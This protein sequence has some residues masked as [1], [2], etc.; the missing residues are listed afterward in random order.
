MQL[1]YRTVSMLATDRYVITGARDGEEAYRLANGV[2]IASC[3]RVDRAVNRLLDWADAQE[4][5]GRTVTYHGGDQRQAV[6]N[7]WA[8]ARCPVTGKLLALVT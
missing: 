5:M 4:L 7:V 6:D 8:E 2:G 3:G 1:S